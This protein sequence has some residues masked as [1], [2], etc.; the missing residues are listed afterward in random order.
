[1]ANLQV[2]NLIPGALSRNPLS[3]TRRVAYPVY[4]TENR[5][6]AR[7]S[8]RV[9][10]E[11]GCGRFFERAESG[12]DPRP[13]TVDQPRASKLKEAR[14]SLQ[15]DRVWSLCSTHE[16]ADGHLY[17]EQPVRQ[18][19]R[20]G[21][22]AQAVGD[23]GQTDGQTGG[24]RDGLRAERAG[25][26]LRWY[27]IDASRLPWPTM[28][29]VRRCLGSQVPPTTHHQP[30]TTNHQP[31]PVDSDPRSMCVRAPHIP[32]RFKRGDKRA[33]F[34]RDRVAV[35]CRVPSPGQSTVHRV[36]RWVL[37][38]TD[39][40][41]H[42]QTRPSLALRASLV[43]QTSRSGSCLVSTVLRSDMR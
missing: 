29:P 3:F 30:P 34:I 7:G 19:P 36:C 11:R 28:P 10:R 5:S 42:A 13:A 33:A 43:R 4:T 18:G 24:L 17:D 32:R 8:Q 6:R 38:S 40:R 31:Q 41:S 25:D 9:H 23:F 22:R 1:M 27:V 35:V 39:V 15:S 2:K 21:R 20:L 16:D 26:D 12:T 14:F 37:T